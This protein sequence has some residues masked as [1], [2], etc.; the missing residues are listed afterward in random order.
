M[1]FYLHNS[2][3]VSAVWWWACAFALSMLIASVIMI[4]SDAVSDPEW[5]RKDRRR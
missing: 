1:G 3:A 5:W 2:M 4:F